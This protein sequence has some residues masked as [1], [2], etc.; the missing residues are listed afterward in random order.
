MSRLNE[1]L[2]YNPAIVNGPRAVETLAPSLRVQ[3][4]NFSYNGTSVLQN[5]GVSLKPGHTLGV[6][7]PIG[8]G[9]T[10]FVKTLMRLLDVEPNQVFVGGVDITE[11][12]L[13]SLRRQFGYVS[14]ENILFSR[15]LAENVAFGAPEASRDA[16]KRA[17]S[18]AQLNHEDPSLP[19]GL[20]TIVGERGITL[21][22]GQKQRT[23]IARALLLDPPVL[24]L[25]DS[26]S[27][28]DS[29]TEESILNEIRSLRA[30]KTTIIVAHRMTAV[31]HADEIIVLDAGV[32]I[33]RG[34]HGTLMAQ[35]GLYSTMVR[36]QE[37]E[38]GLQ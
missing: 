38:E 6:V 17:L 22:G 33:E 27:S 2:D 12:T 7:G 32:V 18:R 37:L 20:D 10:T 24:I 23:A 11:L 5:V 30:D 19:A 36:R 4:L 26:L 16:V 28:V 25:D 3:G 21:S 13:A 8:G 1:I 31:S 35:N 34:N 15:S 29:D 9:K 14:Q